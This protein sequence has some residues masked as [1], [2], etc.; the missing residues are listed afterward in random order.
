MTSSLV[1]S[2]CGGGIPVR[3]R[4]DEFTLDLDIDEMV[5]GALDEFKSLGMFPAETQ[6]L[7]ELWPDSLPAIEYNMIMVAPPEAVDLTPDPDSEDADKY[8]DIDKAAGAITRIDLNRMVLRVEASTISVALPEMRLQVA[9]NKDAL[10][11]DR[12]AWRT[13][14]IIPSAEPGFIGDLEFEFLPGG[15]SFLRSQLWDDEKEFSIRVQSKLKF[16][17]GK[18]PRLPS[19][20]GKL[21][22]IIVATFFVDPVGAI[23]AVQ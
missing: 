22:L 13:I 7:P 3:L 14:G 8:A 23:S 11:E 12:L 18:N 15:E 9:D 5:S 21:R 16:D 20:K 17:T 6:Y 10:E 1:L 19:G 2:T 4:I